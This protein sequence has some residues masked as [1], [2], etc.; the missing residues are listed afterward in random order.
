MKTPHKHAAV[1]KAWA[2]GAEIQCKSPKGYEDDVN[3][4]CGLKSKVLWKWDTISKPSWDVSKEYRVKPEPLKYRLCLCQDSAGKWWIGSFN[5]G[6]G[7]TVAE[8]ERGAGFVKWLDTDWQEV[9]V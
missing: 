8:C 3:L 6:F 5:E 4:A 2:D 9:E 1:I 7:Q